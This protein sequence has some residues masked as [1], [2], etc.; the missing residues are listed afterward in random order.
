M[1]LSLHFTPT[2]GQV[3]WSQ[4]AG[5]HGQ[6]FLGFGLNL[7]QL[8]PM[9]THSRLG[10][11]FCIQTFPGKAGHC[12]SRGRTLLLETWAW[13]IPRFKLK[14]TQVVKSYSCFHVYPAALCKG[15]QDPCYRRFWDVLGTWLQSLVRQWGR[16][17]L[18]RKKIT[19][20]GCSESFLSGKE[21]NCIECMGF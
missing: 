11:L 9:Q 17:E 13:T 10:Q 6:E 20:F 15:N 21:L 12:I 5:N 19:L 14:M 18:A 3:K 8:D 16:E 2:P 7:L 4:I 1:A